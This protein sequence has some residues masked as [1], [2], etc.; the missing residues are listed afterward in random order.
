MCP[1]GHMLP[2]PWERSKKGTL[3]VSGPAAKTGEPGIFSI[4][5]S[6]MDTMNE[7]QIYKILI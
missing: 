7:S 5:F 6:L 2:T 4:A 1:Y 3:D